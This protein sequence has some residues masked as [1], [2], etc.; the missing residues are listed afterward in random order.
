MMI[1]ET[2]LTSLLFVWKCWLSECESHKYAFYE[3]QWK[4]MKVNL[5]PPI[6]VAALIQLVDFSYNTFF[7]KAFLVFQLSRIYK[8]L[9]TTYIRKC[10]CCFKTRYK[11]QVNI[12][13]RK[14]KS[15]KCC[16]NIRKFEKWH[17]L[18]VLQLV[19]DTIEYKTLPNEYLWLRF[20]N[21]KQRLR[22]KNEFLKMQ[23]NSILIQLKPAVARKKC[24]FAN[25]T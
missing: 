18:A 25:F 24:N 6:Q 3:E 16:P 2:Y 10:Y 1:K 19:L 9:M 20:M 14:E 7:K 17:L 23:F 4:W 21:V 12:A 13:A 11:P 5:T 22:E 8:G 15:L